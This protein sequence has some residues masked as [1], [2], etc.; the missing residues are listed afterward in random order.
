MPWKSNIRDKYIDTNKKVTS[1]WTINKTGLC[2][3]KKT[4]IKEWNS[5]LNA[6]K[7]QIEY[8]CQKDSILIK[9]LEIIQLFYDM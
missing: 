6:L 3:L 5:R 4:K 8:W 1:Y 9:T 7:N 2:V